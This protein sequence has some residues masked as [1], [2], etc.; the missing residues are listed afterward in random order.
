MQSQF[1]EEKLKYY[2]EILNQEIPIILSL[3]RE[4]QKPDEF[5]QPDHSLEVAY[6]ELKINELQEESKDAAEQ[7]QKQKDLTQ[8]F[9]SKNQ[10]LLEQNI[11]L[12]KFLHSKKQMADDFKHFYKQDLLNENEHL[13]ATLLTLSPYNEKLSIEVSVLRQ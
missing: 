6:L 5:R 7:L 10:Q 12:K 8:L 13:R 1:S 4:G 2:Y 11:M 3:V 9:R